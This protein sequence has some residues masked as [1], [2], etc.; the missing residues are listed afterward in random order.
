M[1]SKGP[2]HL[3]LPLALF[4]SVLI[5]FF[6][7]IISSGLLNRSIKF[8]F[9]CVFIG[10]FIS[11]LVTFVLF[12]FIVYKKFRT[13]LE[14][15]SLSYIRVLSLAVSTLMTFSFLSTVP[16]NV[17]RS[18]SVWSLN[19]LYNYNKPIDRKALLK[20]GES[21]FTVENGEISRRLGEQVK[22]GNVREYK[23]KLE[24]TRRGEIQA[25][26][27]VLIRK[28]FGLTEKYTSQGDPN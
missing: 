16:L 10:S 21:F 20:D 5:G 2:K 22:L 25:Q 23:G 4:F 28:F 26:F 11:A 12:H 3:N 27:H 14:K 9:T 19:Q 17:D 8:F 6:A 1:G 24:L 7:G 18:F 13:I 15:N